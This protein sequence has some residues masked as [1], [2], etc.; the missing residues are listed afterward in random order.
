MRASCLSV[1]MILSSHWDKP[2]L[3][4]DIPEQHFVTGRRSALDQRALS[5]SGSQGVATY[6][7]SKVQ[8]HFGRQ[9]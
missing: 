4:R 6:N 9:P 7:L 1:S 8:P 2:R 3:A 5:P